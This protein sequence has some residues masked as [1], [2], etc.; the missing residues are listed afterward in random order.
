MNN[1]V[2]WPGFF[3]VGAA[4]AGTTFVWARLRQHPDLFLPEKKEF[5]YF[6]RVTPAAGQRLTIQAVPDEG[7]YL[8]HFQPAPRTALTGEASTSYLWE[9]GTARRIRECVPEARI[10][11]V[12]R[13]PVDRAFSHYR[14]DVALGI[15]PLDFQA[16][17]LEDR[18]KDEKGWGIS[19]LYFEL[20]LYAE[21]IARYLAVFPKS[22]IQVL[23]APDLAMQ[24]EAALSSVC[25]FLGVDPARLPPG[26]PSGEDNAYRIGRNMLVRWLWRQQALRYA[27]LR[28]V[29]KPLRLTLKRRWMDPSHEAP[30]IDFRTSAWLAGLYEPS[31]KRLETLLGPEAHCLRKSRFALV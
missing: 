7:K 6:S 20:G 30:V 31:Q 26:R 10:L 28:L 22:Q 9:P 5:H 18:A 8:R 25:T 3:I 4:K 13:N 1:S 12:L 23:Y 21:Q 16:A 29:P 27:G 14:M 17:V 19:H 11:I 24:P 2:P 15:Q